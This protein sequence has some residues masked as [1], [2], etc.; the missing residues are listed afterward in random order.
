ML[1]PKMGHRTRQIYE[2]D[3]E[4]ILTYLKT[5]GPSRPFQI[6]LACQP[7][8]NKAGAHR[9]WANRWLFRLQLEDVVESVKSI[10]GIIFYKVKD[11]Q[12]N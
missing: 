3:R 8:T 5:H 6:G 11:G 1:H 4:K 9:Q 7:S 12:T 2:R 10:D